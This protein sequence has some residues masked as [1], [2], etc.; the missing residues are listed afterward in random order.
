LAGSRIDREKRI[1]GAMIRIYCRG[2]GHG[3]TL[4]EE[5]SGLLDYSASRLGSCRFGEGKPFCS[6]CKV[7]CYKKGMR[8]RIR[9]VMRYSG[10][11]MV[12]KYPLVA[13]RH[14]LRLKS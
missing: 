10:P 7:H 1:V 2:M 9:E 14:F 6:K 8:D 5:C 13:M 4:C 12:F 11:R 3:E